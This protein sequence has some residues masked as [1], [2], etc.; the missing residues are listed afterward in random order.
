M[1]LPDA[2]QPFFSGT[3]SIKDA[4]ALFLG[5]KILAFGNG[6]LSAAMSSW[7]PLVI[8]LF[9]LSSVGAVFV[10]GILM[11]DHREMV[12]YTLQLTPQRDCKVPLPKQASTKEID[13]YLA[14]PQNYTKAEKDIWDIY[15]DTKN[16]SFSGVQSLET[17][18][19]S[20][21]RVTGF[22]ADG[23]WLVGSLRGQKGR[24]AYYLNA[25]NN[26]NIFRGKATALDCSLPQ[27][28]VLVCPYVLAKP[29]I[30]ELEIG[31]TG[32]V[33]RRFEENEDARP[34]RAM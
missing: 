8:S 21:V 18:G 17:R 11:G 1:G 9:G 20:P 7:K 16:G 19:N 2:T 30:R 25:R 6:V 29:D 10:P 34:P 27:D 22:I 5:N 3:A 24:G 14:D 28:V 33:C 31:L 26:E 23:D 32:Q 12:G 13:D 15:V 4:A